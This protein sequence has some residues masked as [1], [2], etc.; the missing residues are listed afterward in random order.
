MIE[1]PQSLQED[2]RY[3]SEQII[4]YLGNKRALLDFIGQ[5][6]QQICARLGRRKLRCWDAFSGSGVVAR[7]LKQYAAELYANDLEDYSRVLNTC[8]LS[9]KSDVDEAALAQSLQQVREQAAQEMRPGFIAE[10]YAPQDDAHIRPGER[11]FFTRRNAVYIDSVRRAIDA[12]PPGM[13]VYAL[14]PLLYEASVHNN[15]GGVFKGFYKNNQGV[16]QFGGAGQHALER[17]LCDMTLPSP[18]FSR[19]ELPCHVLQM[20]ARAA[21]RRLP[22]LDLAYLDPP[23]NQH[24]YGSNYFMLNQIV[25]NVR[26]ANISA[27]SGI[28]A[29]W[30]RSLYNKR[31][32]A[33]QE[34]FGLVEDCPARFILI[35]YNSEGFVPC[36][37]FV[38]HLQ[39]LGKLSVLEQEYNTFRA[40]RNLRNR[41]TKVREFLF[42]LEKN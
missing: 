27:V 4:T 12:L 38:H 7:F 5:G 31:A 13:Q 32:S 30:N 3:L 34:L 37:A 20:D 21:A 17:I 28:P 35:S 24:P 33:A 2:E 15:T 11:V 40:C 39:R 16:G 42:L 19:F 41:S 1:V 22:E 25:R 18:L 26:P 14:A 9:N 36:D 23:Y 29:D 10:L 8:Y 6:V